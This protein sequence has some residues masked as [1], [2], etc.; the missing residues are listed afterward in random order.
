MY[1]KDFPQFLYDFN[2]GN[3]SKTNVVLDITR[4][5]RFRKEI[6]SNITVYDEYDIVDGE[7]PEI[8]A[9]KFYGTPEYHWVIML[10]N[11]KYDYRN[12]F[13]I[14][15]SVLQKH[16]QTVYNPVL[17]SSDW[18]WE[19]HNNTTYFHIKIT[20]TQ[21]PFD[22]AY[23]TAP[24]KVTITDDDYS[25]NETVN[26]PSSTAGIDAETQYF[27]FKLSSVGTQWLLEHGNEGSTSTQGTGSV[28]LTIKTEGRENN[29]VFFKNMLGNIVNP[30][31]GAIPVT[32]DAIHRTENDKKRRIKII[33]PSLIESILRNYEDQLS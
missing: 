18:Y 23:L 7:T 27:Y 25:L 6:L 15:E 2:Y 28:N 10:A 29:P 31:P 16:I 17:Y 33:S 3:T 32:G 9:E 30:G 4:N 5:I 14:Q 20:S 19:T 13:P 11:E 21:V 1:F 24:I 26:F 22:P 12:D 8:L